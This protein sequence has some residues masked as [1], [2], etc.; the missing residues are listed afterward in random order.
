MTRKQ[1]AREQEQF[2]KN[3]EHSWEMLRVFIA[4]IMPADIEIRENM[5]DRMRELEN[6]VNTYGWVVIVKH[7][8]SKSIPSYDTFIWEGRL[9]EII[10]EMKREDSNILI[11]WNILKPRQ[12]YNIY[13]NTEPAPSQ[14]F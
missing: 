5:E 14:W 10:E 7:I 8:Q 2:Q 9:E 1:S 11:L 6:L 13:R 3:I 4:D 12:I